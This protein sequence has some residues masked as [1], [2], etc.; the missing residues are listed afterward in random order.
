MRKYLGIVLVLALIGCGGAA[1]KPA[2]PTSTSQPTKVAP[3]PSEA[4]SAPS[5]P[6]ELTILHTNDVMGAIEPCG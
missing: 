1:P 2:A 6:F 4:T 3:G 5:G